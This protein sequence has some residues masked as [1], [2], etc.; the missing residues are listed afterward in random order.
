MT[1]WQLVLLAVA[2][3]GAGVIGSTAG[4]AS[5]VSFPALLALGLPPVVA[6]VT[7]TVALIGS[8]VGSVSR[9]RAELRGLGGAVRRA[10]PL[11]VLGGAVGGTLLLTTPSSAFDVVVPYLVALASV[12]LLAAPRIRTLRSAATH[13]ERPRPAAHTG[14]VVAGGL[15]LAYVY[16]GYFGAAAGVMVLALLVVGTDLVLP[17]ATALRNLLMGAANATAAVLFAVSGDVRWAAVLPLG[18]GCLVGGALGPTLVRR[19][20]PT[21]LRVVVALAGL[22]LA[23]RL[24]LT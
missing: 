14:P 10:V 21:V 23:V 9:S 17:R 1:L 11:A 18:I 12:L 6:N 16:G 24:W 13:P 20:P 3:V 4:L 7:N 22:A 19:V 2:G 15:F 5:L 8:S